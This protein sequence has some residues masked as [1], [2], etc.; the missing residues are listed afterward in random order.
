M[1]NHTIAAD[2][3]G[4]HNVQLAAGTVDTFSFADDVTQVAITNM[5]GTAAIYFTVDGTTP[6][7]AGKKSRLVPAAIAQVEIE[8]TTS[9]P[10]TVKVISS[11][12]PTVSVARS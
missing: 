8:P 6:E 9:G 12:T 7:V 10:T 4:V 5:T 1:A 11:G 3:Q 2:E